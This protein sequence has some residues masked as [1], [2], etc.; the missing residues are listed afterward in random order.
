[1]RKKGRTT[2][3]S[4]TNEVCPQ[5]A[6]QTPWCHLGFLVDKQQCKYARVCQIVFDVL[7]LSFAIR[8]QLL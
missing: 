5:R 8:I 7:F 1:M 3:Q 2:Q 4:V 6:D